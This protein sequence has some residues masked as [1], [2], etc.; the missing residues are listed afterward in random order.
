[1]SKTSHQEEDKELATLGFAPS[2]GYIR[3][4]RIRLNWGSF[5][6]LNSLTALG[7]VD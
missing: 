1:M 5:P 2:G 7:L 6:S 3:T 4:S